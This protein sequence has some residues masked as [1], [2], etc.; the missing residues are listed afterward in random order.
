M[1]ALT[2]H[3]VALPNPHI[4]R[5]AQVGHI[6]D[7][8]LRLHGLLGEGGRGEGGRVSQCQCQPPFESSRYWLEAHVEAL[9]VGSRADTVRPA[10]GLRE[11]AAAAVATAA[12][13]PHLAVHFPHPF[14]A[15]LQECTAL[16]PNVNVVRVK[17][18]PAF[19][20]EG[21]WG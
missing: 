9:P 5:G 17:G 14:K 3:L 1:P 11:A 10:V 18:G 2:S 15:V 13:A 4:V 16:W 7:R 6:R 20:A 8:A 19:Q 12:A 21:G